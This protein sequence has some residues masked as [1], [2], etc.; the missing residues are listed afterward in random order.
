MVHL[1]TVVSHKAS[2]YLPEIEKMSKISTD[3]KVDCN[4][5]VRK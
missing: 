1:Q 5:N 3:N 4:L 2:S